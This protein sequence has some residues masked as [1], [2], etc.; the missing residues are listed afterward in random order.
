MFLI[1]VER[2][3]ATQEEE[4]QHELAI[5]RLARILLDGY[6]KTGT[7]QV[8]LQDGR[9]LE[10]KPIYGGCAQQHAWNARAKALSMA[11]LAKEHPRVP[12]RPTTMR[13]R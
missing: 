6:R 2:E 13:G 7:M 9:R 5:V 10:D 8:I 11:R 1:G 12:E 3:L 4:L